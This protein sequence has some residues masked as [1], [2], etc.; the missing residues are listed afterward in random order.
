[1]QQLNGLCKQCTFGYHLEKSGTACV[2]NVCTCKNGIGAFG[3]LCPAHGTFACAYC[4]HAFELKPSPRT[5]QNG[6][7]AR[8]CL[9]PNGVGATGPTWCHGGTIDCASCNVGYH[10]AL[11]SS[12]VRVHPP[13]Q[14]NFPARV[15]TQTCEPNKCECPIGLP[16]TGAECPSPGALLCQLRCKLCPSPGALLCQTFHFVTA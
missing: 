11:T 15:S 5:G 10:L 2:E 7:V 13:G 12:D 1:M 14:D 4:F 9:C 8:S 16:M 3:D 6:C